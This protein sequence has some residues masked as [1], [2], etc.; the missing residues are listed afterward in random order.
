MTTRTK[1]KRL[2]LISIGCNYPNSRYT[3]RGCVNDAVDFS[4][5]MVNL[6]DQ[7]G[8]FVKL[9]LCLD[10]GGS[11][12]PTK[13]FILSILRQVISECNNGT[14]SGF[15][16]YFA[17]HGFQIPDTSGDERDRQDESILGADGYVVRD[18][19]FFQQ[20]TRLNKDKEALFVFDCCHSG[21]MLDLPRVPIGGGQSP[22]GPKNLP[23]SVICVSSCGDKQEAIE[24]GGRGLFTSSFSALLRK[25]GLQS[26]LYPILDNINRYLRSQRTSMTITVS[27]TNRVAIRSSSILQLMGIKN[28]SKSR[29]VGI[30]QTRGGK[31]PQGKRRLRNNQGKQARGGKTNKKSCKRIIDKDKNRKKYMT[32]SG[33]CRSSRYKDCNLSLHAPWKPK[34][35][36]ASFSVSPCMRGNPSLQKKRPNKISCGKTDPKRKCGHV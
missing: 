31:F 23:S 29:G 22:G 6:C 1:G 27:C 5:T 18:D 32:F 24:K 35:T 36:R 12:T 13:N 17:G 19:E 11:R 21:S 28:K 26:R 7:T 33:G 4:T 3:L 9:F 10:T 15:I 34:P 20:L 14:Y 8:I 2:A 25:R 16:F 30:T